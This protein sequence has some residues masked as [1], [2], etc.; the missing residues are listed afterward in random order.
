MVVED[1]DPKSGKPKNDKGQASNPKDLK[2]V[3]WQIYSSNAKDVWDELEETYSKPDGFVIYNM[4][5]NVHTFTQSDLSLAEY[6]HKFNSQWRQYDALVDLPKCVIRFL[7]FKMVVYF[8]LNVNNA[9]L[10]GELVEDAPRKWNEKLSSVLCELGFS[11]SKNDH[12]LFVKSDKDVI[13]VTLVY[14]DDIIIT[15]NIIAE[16]EKFKQLF[17]NELMIKDLGELKYFLGI[18]AMHGPLKS[19]LK[20]AFRVLR[21][22]KGAPGMGVLFKASDSFELTAFVDSDWSK[23]IATSS[24]SKKAEYRAMS[25]VACEII[26]VLK[27]LTDLKVEYTI[28]VEMF[29]DSSAYADCCK[30]WKV[31]GI[32][33]GLLLKSI[34]EKMDIKDF[35][36]SSSFREL[37]ELGGSWLDLVVFRCALVL[38]VVVTRSS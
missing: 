27:I 35:F 25:N 20:L 15:V 33:D 34:G 38:G 12:S 24:P 19:D 11:Q 7:L 37:V 28:L 4:H 8:Q 10:Y 17:S 5:F 14:V 29:C 6:Y 13:V 36:S 26:W 3:P 9:F 16:I 23:C 32:K 21:Y 30:S 18:E 2:I 1:I 31:M 22:L